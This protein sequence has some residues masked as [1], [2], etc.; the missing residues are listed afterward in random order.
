MERS[1]RVEKVCENIVP[2]PGRVVVTSMTM[3]SLDMA[4][5]DMAPWKGG[6]RSLV[7]RDDTSRGVES[8]YKS[9]KSSRPG[10]AGLR[11]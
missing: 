5:S 7:M 3:S 4:M 10:W 8:I 11:T 9:M 2:L 6:I 1:N